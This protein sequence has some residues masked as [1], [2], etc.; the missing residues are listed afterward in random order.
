MKTI[1]KL[2][3]VIISPFLAYFG[4]IALAE[5]APSFIAWCEADVES[6]PEAWGFGALIAC[7]AIACLLLLFFEWMEGGRKTPDYEISMARHRAESL[8]KF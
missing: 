6:Y 2:I 3:L 8:I 5:S 1:I 7:L 4:L